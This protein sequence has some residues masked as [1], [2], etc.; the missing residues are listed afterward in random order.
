MPA[1]TTDP[2]PFRTGGG[3][4]SSLNRI[5]DTLTGRLS[6]RSDLRGVGAFLLLTASFAMLTVFARFLDTGFTIAQQVYLRTAV[7]F[8]I[9][10][11]AF[12]PWIKWSKIP[13]IRPREWAV[14]TVRAILLYVLGTTLFSQA[15]TMSPISDV[16]FIAALPLV[17]VIGLLL[18]KVRVTATRVICVTGSAAGVAILTTSGLGSGPLPISWN[19]GKLIALIAMIALAVSYIGRDWHDNTLNN[20]EITT[21]TVGL[22][23]LGVALV[24]LL[25]GDGIPH[26][27]AASS[28]LILWGAIAVAGVLNVTNVF[29]INYAFEHVDPIRGGNLLT[30][31]GVWGL[32]F[33]WWFYRQMPTLGGIIGGILIIACALGLNL[34]NRQT[35]GTAEPSPVLVTVAPGVVPLRA[36]Q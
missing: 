2:P 13:K 29:L 30:L 15:A 34:V 4:G 18:R 36:D 17:P 9:A 20:L 3:Q 14:I 28:P 8:V 22:G 21:L 16:S 6:M 31:E 23:A 12:G 24:S 27:P 11:V 5:N 10:V 7:A 35:P 26:V 19:S 32:L 25:K 33:G 1:F